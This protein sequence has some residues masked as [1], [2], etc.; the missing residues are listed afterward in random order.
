MIYFLSSIL[1][2]WEVVNL[3]HFTHEETET[4]EHKIFPQDHIVTE[5]KLVQSPW[6]ALFLFPF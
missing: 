3:S 4:Q 6:A 1:K 2:F 5:Q